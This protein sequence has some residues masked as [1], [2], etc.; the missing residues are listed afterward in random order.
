VQVGV[1]YGH[2][3]AV[4]WQN[5]SVNTALLGLNFEFEVLNAKFVGD[6]C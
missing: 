1:G 5:D 6:V 3:W 4:P 2:Q